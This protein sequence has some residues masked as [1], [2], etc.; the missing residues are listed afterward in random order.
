MRCLGEIDGRQNAERLVAHLLT[1]DVST[2]I[3]SAGADSDRWELWVREE[4]RLNFAVTELETFK[5]DP[6]HDRYAG[7][8]DKAKQILL[9]QKQLRVEAAKNIQK[10]DMVVRPGMLGGGRLPPLT[11]TLLILC[12]VLGLISQFGD[13]SEGNTWGI[14]VMRHLSFVDLPLFLE[15]E[16]PLAN[17]RLGQVW[18]IITPIFLHGG[19]IH[20]AMNMFGLVIFGRLIERL[21]GTPRFA[22][23]VLALAILPNLLQG[24]MPS[25]LGGNPLFVGISGV[26]Y[27]FVGY[28]WI[29]DRLN[30][31]F[32]ISIPMPFIVIMVGMMVV[33]LSGAVEGW[34]LADLCHLGGMLVGGLV[35]FASESKK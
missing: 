14:A 28:V 11:L 7:V 16:D 6:N 29:R 27:G 31:N 32:G 10:M 8:V 5:A 19:A 22:V 15:T 1:N 26:V 9:A 24:L 20:L 25:S 30:P 2:H 13:L 17:I 34:N 33:G 4:D 35:G 12:I 18:R 23:F 3:E 21:M